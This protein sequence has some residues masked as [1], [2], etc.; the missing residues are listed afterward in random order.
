MACTKVI[1]IHKATNQYTVC[2]KSRYA[3]KSKQMQFSRILIVLKDVKRWYDQYLTRKRLKKRILT[4]RLTLIQCL[5]NHLRND[6]WNTLYIVAI[7][8]KIEFV[9]I[10]CVMNVYE[11]VVN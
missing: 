9:I 6:F 1:I 8:I 7:Y 10:L 11:Y 2:F 3:V 4:K 5:K